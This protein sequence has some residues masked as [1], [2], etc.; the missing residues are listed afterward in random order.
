MRLVEVIITYLWDDITLCLL[1]LSLSLI[2]CWHNYDLLI[3]FL[4]DQSI[5]RESLCH[6]IE[7]VD[8]TR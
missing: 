1:L 3:P 7:L 4:L 5:E 6:P 8:N 2:Y